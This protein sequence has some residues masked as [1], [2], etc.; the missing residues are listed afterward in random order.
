MKNI[1]SLSK[2]T[3]EIEKWLDLLENRP[4]SLF[5]YVEEDYLSD[6]DIFN[7]EKEIFLKALEFSREIYGQ[8]EKAAV[9]RIPGRVNLLGMHIL[10]PS[11]LS[12]W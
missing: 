9:L 11:T 1:E 4:A 2:N 10:L 5:Q 12:L 8:S 7:T 6:K 3:L